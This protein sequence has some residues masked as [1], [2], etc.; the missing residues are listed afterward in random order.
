MQRLLLSIA[1]TSTSTSSGGGRGGE[2]VL[3]DEINRIDPHE[4]L[5]SNP[6]LLAPHVFFL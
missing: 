3:G 2:V 4:V 1:S 5:V 6:L